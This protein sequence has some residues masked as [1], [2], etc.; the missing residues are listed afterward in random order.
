[1]MSEGFGAAKSSVIKEGWLLKRGKG[2]AVC[3]HRLF[4]IKLTNVEPS[5]QVNT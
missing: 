3:Y 1:M 2:A 5:F 4:T